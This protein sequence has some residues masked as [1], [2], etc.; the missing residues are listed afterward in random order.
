MVK[1]NLVCHYFRP[2]IRE[3]LTASLAKASKQLFEGKNL[4]GL[5]GFIGLPCGS[6]GK[7]SPCNAGDSGSIPGLGR[8]TVEGNGSVQFSCQVVSDSL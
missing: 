1:T 2:Y 8:S 4:T 3:N 6:D 7:E 5:C